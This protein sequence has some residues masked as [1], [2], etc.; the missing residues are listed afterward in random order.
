M[1]TTVESLINQ[2]KT[3]IDQ[4]VDAKR[5]TGTLPTP[6][7]VPA[8]VAK[9]MRQEITD[10]LAS[11]EAFRQ[12]D[13]KRDPLAGLF[14]LDGKI[15][16]KQRDDSV[17]YIDG[18][19]KRPE[20][21][22][23]LAEFKTEAKRA[24]AMLEAVDMKNLVIAGGSVSGLLTGGTYSD[25]DL[26][27]VGL[28]Q[29]QANA[30]ISALAYRLHAYWNQWGMRMKVHRTERAVTFEPY[31]DPY[32]T[33]FGK[34]L[35]RR[36]VQVILRLYD[37]VSEVLHGFDLGAC[38]MAFDGEN[39]FITA[40]AKVALEYGLNVVDM[41]RRKVSY[42]HRLAKYNRRGFAVV[43]PKL[44]TRT[45]AKKR[46]IGRMIHLGFM[47]CRMIAFNGSRI[48]ISDAGLMPTT[49]DTAT[50]DYDD[51]QPVASQVNYAAP[52]IVISDYFTP[53]NVAVR[54]FIEL[55]A[56]R[57]QT[58]KLCASAYY[59]PAMDVTAFPINLE[60]LQAALVEWSK[61]NA[62][63]LMKLTRVFGE[64]IAKALADNVFSRMKIFRDIKAGRTVE[65]KEIDLDA[66]ANGLAKAVIGRATV[67]V[68]FAG[69]TDGTSLRSDGS[70]PILTVP[71]AEWYGKW[72]AAERAGI[73]P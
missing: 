27:I 66:L 44:E 7:Q 39:V 60:Y 5:D 49:K 11:E 57:P 43:T 21:A 38:A 26:F 14:K 63:N 65:H 25:I 22:R 64:N 59:Y 37:S 48:T 45:F 29:K 4:K 36:T 55:K 40:T 50:S 19:G 18:L 10:A 58:S 8:P 28:S 13:A 1:A 42:E 2:F 46:M 6:T 24:F 3:T 51:K 69:A 33:P 70:F 34:V 9:T 52:K 31:G 15:L 16:T 67:P 54:N 53:M 20:C 61:P 35:E 47:K 41:S 56:E 17:T 62:F 72:F 23:N 30:K 73:A 32:I 12:P 71:E 68:G